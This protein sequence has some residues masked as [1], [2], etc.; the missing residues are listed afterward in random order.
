MFDAIYFKTLPD[1]LSDIFPAKPDDV[2]RLLD[3][4]VASLVKPRGQ[5]VN[6]PTGYIMLPD[7]LWIA[8]TKQFHVWYKKCR[9]ASNK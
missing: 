7:I 6:F 8:N 1:I 4:G 5:N 3:S 2:A 9:Y